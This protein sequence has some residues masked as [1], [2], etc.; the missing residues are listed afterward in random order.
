S[1][2]P[3]LIWEEMSKAYENGMG[4]FWILNVGDIKPGEIGTEL[5]LQMA[6]DAKRWN[7]DNTDQFLTKWAERE[8]GENDSREIGAVMDEYF[9]LGFQRKPEHL[10]WYIPGEPPRKSNLSE[11]E[12]LKRLNDYTTL[13][14]RAEEIYKQIPATKKDAFYELVLYPVRSAASANERFFAAELATRYQETKPAKAKAWTVRA[15]NADSTIAADAR[16]F[17]NELANGKWRLIISPEMNPGQWTSIRSTQPDLSFPK[18]KG[19]EAV[20][21]LDI[22]SPN[23]TPNKT[24]SSWGSEHRGMVK[25]FDESNGAISIEAEHFQR[26]NDKDGFGWRVIRGLGK[27]GDSVSVFPSLA[28][29]F[30]GKDAPSLEYTI[31]V[32]TDADFVV[33]FY[34]LPTQPLVYGTGLRIGFAI[35]N[36]PSQV[37]ALDK[38]AE[39]SGQKWSY[40]VLNES[41]IGDAKINLAAGTHTLRVFAVDNGVVLDKIVFNSGSVQQSYFG[42]PETAI[43]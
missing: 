27:T 8:F 33:N 11:D 4:R 40:N 35:D 24:S 25:S 29:T 6:W 23:A 28:N 38:D 42:P 3:A 2:P 43:Y 37:V 21:S 19:I 5:F 16:Y 30:S 15:V 32:Q 26:T 14:G 34:L 31:N 22:S 41:T 20:A 18:L 9:R 17:N 1:T 10:Q 12:I 7:L 13:Q 39:V 36:D